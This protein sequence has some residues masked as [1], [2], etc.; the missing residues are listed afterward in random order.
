MIK[1]R[2]ITTFAAIAGMLLLIIDRGSAAAGGREGV[3]L[4]LQ[5][6]IPSL[7]PFIVLSTYLTSGLVG[8]NIPILN[9]L[10]KFCHIPTGSES[11]LVI[12]FLG[13]Y[14]VGAQNISLAQKNGSISPAVAQRMITFCNNAGP[15]FI[16]GV[17]S[18][19]FTH[20]YTAWIL[21]MIHILSALIVAFLL[22]HPK[23]PEVKIQQAKPL[24]FSMAVERSLRT[25]ASICGWVILFR[26]LL[27]F[28]D[29][30]ILSKL[31][32]AL[33]VLLTGIL[34][35]TNG[36][37]RLA[38]IES[39][40]LRF[41]TASILLA[42][43]G[44]CVAMQTLSVAGNVKLTTYFPGKAL[45]CFISFLLSILVISQDQAQTSKLSPVPIIILILFWPL[46]TRI[47][48]KK[49]VAF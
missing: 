24:S 8:Q 31:S 3:M 43:G 30:I 37:V 27:E 26:M 46:F 32:P 1:H 21:W 33:S 9:G 2:H 49:E 35:L 44:G 11:L 13:G 25:M 6:L 38:E 40:S 45:Q 23:V 29:K 39:E 15:S 7:F 19:M 12:G 28:L 36:C 4:C 22:P 48:R 17:I 42:L 34:E 20:W 10:C 41:M 14:P 16:F 18:P 5:V 47:I